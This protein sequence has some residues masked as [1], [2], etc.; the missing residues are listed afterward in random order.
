MQKIKWGI[1]APGHIARGFVAGLKALEGAELYAVAS[2]SYNKA[3]AFAKEF[4]FQ[5]V[6][7]SYSELADD[8]DVDVIYVATPH[9]LHFENAMM[10]IQK[11]KAVLCEKPFTINSKQLDILVKTAREKKVFLMEAVWTRFLPGI[12][13]T[14]ELIKE[15]QI[16]EIKMLN[17]DFGFQAD[18]N[19]ESRL[20]NPFLGGG[21]LLDIGIYPVFLSLLLL[22]YPKEIKAVAIKV[23]T[24]VDESV[25]ISLA[26]ESGALASLY[27]TFACFTTTDADIYGDKGKIH[28]ETQWFRPTEVVLSR[29]NESPEELSFPAKANGYEYEALEVMKCIENGFT[30]SNIL[31]L[32]FSLQLMKLLDAIRGKC[33][34][35]YPDYD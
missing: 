29:N 10:C 15:G 22:G 21:S 18:Y 12:I 28:L 7:G 31:G 4:G 3:A 17:A 16:G 11:G 26:Y 25:S 24:G 5:K 14:M 1:L 27:C 33:N 13:K 2:R 32:D 19:P 20:F 34:I 30:E 9:H 23:P 8:P 6:Y 35:V